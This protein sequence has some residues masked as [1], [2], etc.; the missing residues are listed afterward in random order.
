MVGLN[1][2]IPGLMD[3]SVIG[4]EITNFQALGIGRASS[5]MVSNALSAARN[6]YAQPGVTPSSRFTLGNPCKGL[7]AP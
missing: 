1:E 2:Q 6:P 4:I 3:L 7:L 5:S